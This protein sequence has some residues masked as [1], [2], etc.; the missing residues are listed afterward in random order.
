ME[1]IL[2]RIRREKEEFVQ[3]DVELA[4]GYFFNQRK[5]IQ[6]IENYFFSRFE[7]GP[8]DDD[9][10]IK[11]FYNV[12]VKPCRVASKEIDL[13][14]KDIIIRPENGDYDTADIMAADFKQWMKDEGF[15][16]QLNEYA[17]FCPEYGSVVIKKV[18]EKLHTVDLKKLY[19]TNVHAKDLSETNTIE[20]NTYSRDEFLAMPWDEEK[21]KEVVKLYDSISRVDI[22]VDER[23]GWV[24]ES[25]LVEGGSETKMVF[26]MCIAAGT[27]I[28]DV[29]GGKDGKQQNI[30]E[31]GVVLNHVQT[32]EKPYREW[33]WSR[34]PNRWLGVGFVELLFDGQVRANEI[35]YY[36]AKA[37]AWLGLHLF[38]TDDDTLTRNLFND[39]RDG[40]VV[41]LGLQR[42][43]TE[44]PIQERNLGYYASEEGRWDKNTA[45]LT[46]TPEIITG[47]GLPSGT[48]ARSAIISDQNVKRY[49]D[50]KREDFG[51]FIKKL[52]EDDILPLFERSRGEAHTFSFSGSGNDRDALERRVFNTRM[53]AIFQ[54]YVARK[55]VLPSANEWRRQMLIERQR[56]AN[57]STIDVDVPKDAY[58]N[59]R[60]RLDVVITKENEDTDSKLAGRQVVLQ[61]L[62]ANPAIATNPVTR[63]VFM[64]LANLLGVKNLSLPTEAEI[65]TLQ[66]PQQQPAAGGQLPGGA[67]QPGA[68][69]VLGAMPLPQGAAA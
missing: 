43:L 40:D 29:D 32:D 37:L 30:V 3:N 42:T 58:K 12:V 13:D 21:K 34:M 15:A 69:D 27:Q 9:G 41:R 23:Y 6:R 38:A 39:V 4:P 24:K 25:E 1:N 59:L 55:G 65:L 17:D 5:I 57:K 54:D 35:A 36:K 18:K 61:A 64:E 2:G 28:Y 16:A 67:R 44:V 47:E 20:T 49:F 11:P 62:A 8:T 56:I 7:S 66:Q 46:F 10:W 22:D 33:H 52:I 51:I 50:R 45:D 60:K 48:P 14:T 26:T 19:L 68:Q 53:V 63:P 31:K